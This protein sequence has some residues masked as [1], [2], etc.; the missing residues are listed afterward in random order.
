MCR[1]CVNVV[2]LKPCGS[3]SKHH[4]KNH[5]HKNRHHVV[6]SSDCNSSDSNTTGCGHRLP[7]SVETKPT[8][9]EKIIK[10]IVCVQG[11]CDPCDNINKAITNTRNLMDY[12]SGRIF[13]LGD[14]IKA[15]AETISRNDNDVLDLPVEQE[16]SAVVQA[17]KILLQNYVQ[18]QQQTGVLMNSLIAALAE[19]KSCVPIPCPD[20]DLP[21]SPSPSPSPSPCPSTTVP[22]TTSIT[23]TTST[24]ST[25]TTECP[26]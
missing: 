13:E 22:T 18:A 9:I 26:N 16:I 5:H 3:L 14:K 7:H 2:P 6:D 25:T 15:C 20:N 17:Y 11:N 12:Y 10:K 8:V 19:C 4:Y 24:T 21:Y 23:S 1:K